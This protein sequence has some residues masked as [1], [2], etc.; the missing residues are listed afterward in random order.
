MDSAK[1]LDSASEFENALRKY[2]GIWSQDAEIV[3][4]AAIVEHFLNG[5]WSK[6]INVQGQFN[7]EESEKEMML[8]FLYFK[9]LLADKSPSECKKEF[10]ELLEETTP[11]MKL[12]KQRLRTI[13]VSGEK[14]PT[15]AGFEPIF[16][17][18]QF[19]KDHPEWARKGDGTNQ[20]P[21]VVFR[22]HPDLAGMSSNA[23]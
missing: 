8:L 13:V 14:T 5:S 18:D 16:L 23:L 10:T 2:E 9:Q 20:D 21:F 17:F 11:K 1:Q 7:N 15:R 22:D 6:M 3:D 4:F 12:A 19:V